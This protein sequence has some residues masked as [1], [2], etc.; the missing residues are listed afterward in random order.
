MENYSI[1][2]KPE[3]PMDTG[4]CLCLIRAGINLNLELEFK[5]ELYLSFKMDFL[6]LPK[7]DK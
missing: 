6:E 4:G 5:T 2:Q 1:F 7:R 3:R